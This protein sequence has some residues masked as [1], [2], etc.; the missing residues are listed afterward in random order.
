L[1]GK[2]MV[3]ALLGLLALTV[4]AD[5]PTGGPPGQGECDHGNSG[6]D[7]RPDPQPT[8]G[9]DCEEHGNQGGVNEDHCTGEEEPSPTPTTETPSPTPSSTPSPTSS[10]TPSQPPTPEVTPSVTTTPSPSTSATPPVQSG[11]PNKPPKDEQS[12]PSKKNGS[13]GRSTGPELAFTGIT[14]TQKKGLLMVGLSLLGLLALGA[15]RRFAK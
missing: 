4:A 14:D 2:F 11:G 9:Q 7:C 5:P 13:A 1:F 3:F 10:S 12:G 8:H 15:A 6:Q